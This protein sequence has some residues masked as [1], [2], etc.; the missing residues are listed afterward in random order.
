MNDEWS[1]LEGDERLPELPQLMLSSVFKAIITGISWQEAIDAQG[2]SVQACNVNI[3]A[4]M[5][6]DE[7]NEL[8]KLATAR[9]EIEISVSPVQPVEEEASMFKSPDKGL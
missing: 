6:Q 1:D 5:T 8:R 7:Y 4:A 9:G 2:R 3:I